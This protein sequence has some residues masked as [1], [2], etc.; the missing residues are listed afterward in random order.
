MDLRLITVAFDPET[1][2]FPEQPLKDV[3][4]E[5]VNVV[6]HF[7]H[8]LEQPHLLLV[9]HVRPPLDDRRRSRHRHR[10]NPRAKL[11]P[12]AAELYDRLRAWRNGRAQ[13]EGVPP[14][15]LFNNRHLA[16]IARRRPADK[17]SLGE[18][19]GVGDRKVSRYGREIL[20]VVADGGR[21]GKPVPPAASEQSPGGSGDA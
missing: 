1:G 21:G 8:H 9:V 19:D 2:G 20:Q 4:C 18:I 10:E 6:E 5:I 7:F 3:D 15:V 16:E 14:Y 12:A 11:D 13:T 17:T